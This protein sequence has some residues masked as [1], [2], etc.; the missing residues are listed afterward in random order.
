MEKKE[1]NYCIPHAIYSYIGY[2]RKQDQV[3]LGDEVKRHSFFAENAGEKIKGAL[4]TLGWVYCVDCRHA[5]FSLNEAL[6]HLNNGHMLAVEFMPDM[7]AA[8]EAPAV[9]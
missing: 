7:V 2:Y 4:E 6:E 3:V 8:E 1:Y 5:I 9:D